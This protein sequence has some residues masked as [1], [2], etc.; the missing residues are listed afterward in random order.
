MAATTYPSKP[1]VKVSLW[2]VALAV[3]ASAPFAEHVATPA[4][5]S[6][7]PENYCPSTRAVFKT[8]HEPPTHPHPEP[9][10]PVCEERRSRLRAAA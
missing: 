2:L 6:A 4:P 3:V 8:P 10:A 7:A 9:L 1:P 5:S